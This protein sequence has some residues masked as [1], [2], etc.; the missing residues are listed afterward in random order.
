[1]KNQLLQ[2]AE[3]ELADRGPDRIDINRMGEMVDMVKDLAEAEKSCWEARYYQS[4][5]GAMNQPQG[6]MQSQGYMQHTASY[7]KLVEQLGSEYSHLSPDEKMM[8]KS[9][10][11]AKFNE[12]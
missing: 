1:M 12:R 2:Q 4:I 9:K 11:L 6:Y 5:V 3:K 8:M 7:D 10:V